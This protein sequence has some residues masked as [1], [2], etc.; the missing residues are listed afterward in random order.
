MIDAVLLLMHQG[1]SFTEELRDAAEAH[2]LALVALSSSPQKAEHFQKSKPF[3]RRWVVTDRPELARSDLDGITE[4][5]AR[6]GYRIRAAIATFESYRLLMAELNRELGVRDSALEPLRLC[7]DKYALRQFLVDSGLSRVSCY[8]LEPGHEPELDPSTA[9]F[10]KPVRGAGSFA[11]FVLKDAD[12]FQALPRLQEQMKNDN[13]MGSIFMGR[14]DFLVEE[15]IDG[16]EFSFE[17]IM[18]GDAFHLCVHEKARVE[19][20]DWTTLELMSISPPLTLNSS[21]LML[22]AEFVTTCL[23]TV[24]LTAG[25]FHIEAKYWTREDRWEIIEIN[26]RMGGSLINGSVKALTGCCMLELWLSSLLAAPEEEA[27]LAE[28]LRQ[29]SQLESMKTSTPSKATVFLSKYGEQG[30]TIDSISFEPGSPEPS[31]AKVH[32]VPGT[33]LPDSSRMICLMDALWQV[34][35]SDLRDEVGRLERHATE[36]FHVAY[37]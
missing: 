36:H 25:A 24:G 18:A 11:A 35:Y 26:P 34:D 4:I 3:L 28:R 5:F 20:E 32:V 7:L 31:I 33:Q 19:R 12:D 21:A 1:R 6:A 23:K 22:G 8:P 29:I 30:K 37:R 14:Y 13:K 15:Y 27:G 2:G 17:T 16:P 10:V 9:W